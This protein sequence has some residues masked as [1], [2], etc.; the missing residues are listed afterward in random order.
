MSPAESPNEERLVDLLDA[1]LTN[2]QAGKTLDPQSCSPQPTEWTDEAPGLLQTLQE[3]VRAT[4]DWR[5]ISRGVGVAGAPTADYVAAPGEA[6]GATLSAAAASPLGQLGRYRLLDRLGTGGMGVVYKGFD[7]QLNRLV[8]VKLPRLDPGAPDHAAL[9]RRLQREAQ[10]AAAVRHPHVCPVYDVGEQDGVAYLVMA[11][12][13]GESLAR[14]LGRTG[15][16]DHAAEAV[17]IV[18]QVAEGLVAV[19]AHGMVH[20]DLKPGNILLDA[21]GQALLS[22]FGLAFLRE[23]EE[24]LSTAGAVV[25]TLRYMAPEQAAGGSAPPGPAADQYSLGVVLYEML[26]GEAPFARA[27]M[28]VARNRLLYEAP[29]PLRELRPDVDAG[30]AALVARAMARDP[31]QRFPTVQAFADALGVWLSGTPPVTVRPSFGVRRRALQVGLGLAAVVLVACIAWLVAG[32]TQPGLPDPGPAAVA[33]NPPQNE[34][35]KGDLLVTVSTDPEKPHRPE[36]VKRRIPVE[37]PAALPVRNGELVHLEVRLNRPAY[38]YLLWVDSRGDIQP[39]YPW[40]IAGSELGWRAPWVRDGKESRAVVH[41]PADEGRGLIVEGPPGLETAVLLA[42]STP[43]PEDVNLE[44]LVGKLPPCP[45]QDP[46]EVVW[47]GLEPGELLA[48]HERPPLNRGLKAGQSREMD[49]SVFEL[50]EKRLRP[51][52]EL[53]KAVRFAHAE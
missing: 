17:R 26:C 45:H 14:R 48:R 44:Q 10:A 5:T 47:L 40:D 49:A 1:A 33:A 51:R 8:A 12:V 24:R 7:P 11:Y 9:M 50:L 3:L 53:L 23:A 18:R 32:R 37:R 19:H 15:R 36:A 35:L 13:E 28:T 4:E 6:G 16:F 2:L 43:L 42:R 27:G 38:V 41:C 30:L 34:P 25:G 20:R 39:A 21:Q 31:V 52:F 29:P 46:R 22:D